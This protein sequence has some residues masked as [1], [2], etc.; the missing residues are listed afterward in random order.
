MRILKSKYLYAV[1]AAAVIAAVLCVSYQWA[2]QNKPFVKSVFY[3]GDEELNQNLLIAHAGGPTPEGIRG[4][5]SKEAIENSIKR[6]FK[7]IEIDLLISTD[8]HIVAA[9]DW[10]SFHQMTG[11]PEQTG[12]ISREEFLR[13]SIQGKYTPVDGRYI[14]RIM[15]DNTGLILVT[16]KIKEYRLL[17]KELNY[18]DRMIVEVFSMDAYFRA[19]RAGIKYPALET[20]YNGERIPNV[21]KYKI[22]LVT[23]KLGHITDAHYD[24]YKNGV[25]V[26]MHPLN[27]VGM[28]YEYF[29]LPACMYYTNLLEEFP[30]AEK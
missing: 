27:D 20:S 22:P 16:D 5:N 6:G 2:Q 4:T 19:L 15:R 21:Y 1:L 28:M 7:F 26:L 30:P 29:K 11:Y 12:P 25:T 8:G 17:L 18:P 23:A 24:L 14:D 13:R 9:H 10:E 3:C